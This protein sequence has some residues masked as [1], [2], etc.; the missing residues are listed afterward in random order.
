MQGFVLDTNLFF[1]MVSGLGLGNKTEELM[2][3]V[4]SAMKKAREKKQAEFFM[5]PRVVDELLGFFEDKNQA[6]L[7]DFQS[8]ITVKSPDISKH[9]FPAQLFYKL[10]ED[11]RARSLRGLNIAVDEVKTAYFHS[12]SEETVKLNKIE[13]QK[14]MGP[15]LTRLR[16]KYRVATRSGFLDSLAD[17]DLIVLSKELDAVMVSTDEG[18]V[19]WGRAFGVKEM[20]AQSFGEWLTQV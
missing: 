6:F 12:N 2:V 8:Q 11:I 13:L 3:N 14:N 16:E 15:V 17:L 18:V 4:T 10:I 19:D 9:Q 7:K 20:T 1:N 5:P